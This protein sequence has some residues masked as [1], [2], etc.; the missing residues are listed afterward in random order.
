MLIE[1]YLVGKLPS[2]LRATVEAGKLAAH[3]ADWLWTGKMIGDVQ[4]AGTKVATVTNHYDGCLSP[5]ATLHSDANRVETFRVRYGTS[6]VDGH[7]AL[8]TSHASPTHEPGYPLTGV[9]LDGGYVP[10]ATTLPPRVAEPTSAQL[11]RLAAAE[12]GRLVGRVVHPETGRPLSAGQV[13][14]HGSEDSTYT[15]VQG[16]GTFGVDA[17]P[18]GDYRLFVHSLGGS[19]AGTWVGGP[20]IE[21]ARVF[22]VQAGTTEAGDVSGIPLEQVAVTLTGPDGTPVQDGFAVLVDES[23]RQVASGKADA[24]GTVTLSAPPGSYS[25]G[26]ASPTTAAASAEVDLTRPASVALELEPAALV[27]ATVKDENGAPLPSVAVALY[28]GSDVVAVGFTGVDGT[29]R[30]T[31]LDP[32]DYTVKLYEALDRFELPEVVL[33][34]TAVVGDPAAGR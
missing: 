16:D 33:P 1:D 2:P 18:A 20:T 10:Q 9:V 6:G 15:S 22:R 8:L 30:F 11:S 21:E 28:S 14:V 5:N 12:T 29:H 4:D 27:T 26:A 25:L 17:L 13:V 3:P 31:G 19:A 23:G 32:G 7:M 34:A 24:A